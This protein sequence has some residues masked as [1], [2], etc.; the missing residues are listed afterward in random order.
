MNNKETDYTLTTQY[1]SPDYPVR[2]DFLEKK[3]EDALKEDFSRRPDDIEL[4]MVKNGEVNVLC[5]DKLFGAK[6]GQGIVIEQG[7]LHR[8]TTS[9]KEDTAYYSLKF[10]PEYVIDSDSSFYEKYISGRDDHVPTCFLLDEININ[11]ENLIDRI[12][13]IIAVNLIR[14]PGYEIMTR[15]NLCF[16]FL[17]LMEKMGQKSTVF[18]ARNMPSQDEL[19]VQSASKFIMEN[20]Q[21]MVTLKDIADHIHVSENECCRCFKR[22]LNIP[23]G[24]YL[25]RVRIFEAAKKLYKDPAGVQSITELCFL[26]GFNTESYFIKTFRKYFGCT[27]KQF[28]K[29]LKERPEGVLYKYDALHESI[30]IG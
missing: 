7:A 18:N 15:G 11:D 24:E 22:V 13:N 1:D 20:Y 29:M 2:V 4:L 17:G 30:L 6:A 21:D 14:K 5:N 8:I 16:L 23:P 3:K 10:S 9:S 27:P 25:T 12:N 26:V 28:T 19:R